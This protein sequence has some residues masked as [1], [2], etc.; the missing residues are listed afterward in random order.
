MKDNIIVELL[1]IRMSQVLINEEYKAGKFKI[2]VHLSFGHEAIAV[3]VNNLMEKGDKLI[4]S[5]RNMAYNLARAENVRS[6]LDEYL[7]KNEGMAGGRLGSMNLVNTSRD[8]IY[9]SSILGNN[10][11]VSAG[12]AMSEKLKSSNNVTF[13]LGGDGS[14]EEGSFYESLVLMKSIGLSVIVVIENNEWSLGT[15][16]NERRKCI[17]L[18]KL[19]DSLGLK[20]IRFEG[21]D[22]DSYIKMLTVVR[23]E[24]IQNCE[25]ICIEVILKTLGD[26]C[27]PPSAE[28]PEG[29]Y[30]NYHAGPSSTVDLNSELFGAILQESSNDPIFVLREKIGAKKFGEIVALVTADL[31]D[32]LV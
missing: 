1:R 26:R 21:N 19:T 23:K 17:D 10:F 27:D 8:V 16:I 14:M 11:S 13:V 9:S 29:K 15:H 3:A 2:P 25:P 22:I 30:I 24:C 18:A 12:I 5:H 31:K 6:I 32:E 7:L 28:Y 4:L 20:Y